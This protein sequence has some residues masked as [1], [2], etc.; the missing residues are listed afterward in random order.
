MTAVASQIE[1]YL[2][3]TS[4]REAIVRYV[5]LPQMWQRS[6]RPAAEGF[7]VLCHPRASHC[8]Q[9]RAPVPETG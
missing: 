3:V 6:P 1:Q 5:L 7:A 8:E 9:W 2:T 4:P